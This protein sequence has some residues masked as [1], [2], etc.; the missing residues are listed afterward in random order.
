MCFPLPP[1]TPQLRR[2]VL[3]RHTAS[4]A[5][6][7]SEAFVEIHQTRADR[8]AVKRKRGERDG[9]GVTNEEKSKQC[10]H[11]TDAIMKP[12]GGGGRE[13]TRGETQRVKSEGDTR[14]GIRKAS[15]QSQLS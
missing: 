1:P 8:Q 4:R 13:R 11:Q 12:P 15:N 6:A 3:S 14:H 5:I 9:S 2:F 10:H 7:L